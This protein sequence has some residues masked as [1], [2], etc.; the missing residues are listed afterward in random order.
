MVQISDNN[1]QAKSEC[2]NKVDESYF[3][4]EESDDDE[5]PSK[6]ISE[7]GVHQNWSRRN[8]AFKQTKENI[9]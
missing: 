6:L 4:L 9:S 8:S 2:F 7:L 3:N 5:N 1:W